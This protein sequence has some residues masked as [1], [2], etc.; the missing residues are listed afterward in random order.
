[1]VYVSRIHAH[2]IYIYIYNQRPIKLKRKIKEKKNGR[3]SPKKYKKKIWTI[4]SKYFCPFFTPIF[5]LIWRESVLKEEREK[6]CRP[7]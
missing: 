4:L 5:S 6:T 3:S 1:M 7:Y 2:H